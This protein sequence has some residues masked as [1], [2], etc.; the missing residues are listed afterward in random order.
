[1]YNNIIVTGDSMD[2]SFFEVDR[3]NNKID[4]FDKMINGMNESSQTYL[5]MFNGYFTKE[6]ISKIGIFFERYNDIYFNFFPSSLSISFTTEEAD[7]IMNSLE[8]TNSERNRL[9][10]YCSDEYKLKYLEEKMEQAKD[11]YFMGYG[12]SFALRE[13]KSIEFK[14][15]A[16]DMISDWSKNNDKN[17]INLNF[18]EFFNEGEVEFNLDIVDYLMKNSK[19]KIKAYRY[20]DILKLFPDDMKEQLFEKIIVYEKENKSDDDV[21]EAYIRSMLSLMPEEKRIDLF[22]RM[23]YEGV[24]VYSYDLDEL[25]KMFTDE[26]K[27]KILYIISLYEEENVGVIKP[28]LNERVLSNIISTF[29]EEKREKFFFEF[30]NNRN[31]ISI[32]SFLIFVMG[33]NDKLGFDLLDKYLESKKDEIYKNEEQIKKYYYT[34]DYIF[35]N[36][37]V[38]NN[39]NVNEIRDNIAS[40]YIK[41]HNLNKENF[42][43]FISKFGCSSLRF[44]N[45][46]NVRKF[47]NLDSNSFDKALKIFNEE[48]IN[49]N[50]D[51]LN[52]IINSLLQREFLFNNSNVYNIFSYLER[53]VGLA[54]E[55][56]RMEVIIILMGIEKN[57]N[58]AKIL[59]SNNTSMND[60]VDKLFSGDKEALMVLHKITDKYIAKKREDYAKERMK[61]IYDELSLNKKYE[62]NYIKKKFVACSQIFDIK[63]VLRYELKTDNLDMFQK[64]LVNDGDLLDKIIEFKKNPHNNDLEIEHKKEYLRAFDDLLNMAYEQD[65]LKD[66]TDDPNAKYIYSAKKVGMD[67]L[68]NVITELDI[69]RL[70]KMVDDEKTYNELL[71]VLKKFKFLGWGDMFDSMA[72]STDLSF[73]DSAV[74]SLISYFDE[75]IKEMKDSNYSITKLLA[76]SNCYD[77]ESSKYSLLIGKED[78]KYYAANSGK[79]KASA[80]KYKRVEALPELVKGMYNRDKVCVPP[81]DEVITLSNGKKINVVIGNTTN[82]INLTLGERTEACLR[83]YG[84][85]GDLFK[86][87]LMGSDSYNIVL[88]DPDT[89]KFISR[90]TVLCNGNTHF[91]NEL[92]E[93]CHSD[94]SNEDCVEALKKACNMEIVRSRDSRNPIS[95]FVI[96]SDYAMSSYEDKLQPLNVPAKD[97]VRGINHNI[98]NDSTAILLASKEKDGSLSE[99]KLGNENTSYYSPQRDKILTYQNMAAQKRLYQL[100]LIDGLLSGKR[101]EDIEIEKK[102]DIV[103]CISGEDWCIC[104]D[105]YGNVSSYI[106]QNS[107]YREMALIEME[108]YM[109]VKGE[110]KK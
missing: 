51:D 82:M 109:N 16:I 26:D 28:I 61:T 3:I 79:N 85:F 43:K 52:N 97:I 93:S 62:K 94:Y 5:E 77:G 45:C 74:A 27:M 44:L 91:C 57:I 68:L 33:K 1:M 107:K 55:E 78:Y 71:G 13:I 22:E 41:Y 69:T 110:M 40:L 106:V 12:V 8:L 4:D 29:D 53:L 18:D 19:E 15:K 98:R 83:C 72:E 7:K 70:K 34:V 89:M 86:D 90:V 95:N 87:A 96:T 60:L 76:I 66:P 20:V 99:I 54:N 104:T 80:T 100:Q 17:W 38:N 56:S 42:N 58:I 75:V 63:C 88:Y 81:M 37:I 92:R 102:S 73:D 48:N 11:D 84:A 67:N 25:L 32:S 59:K 50:N 39:L 47:I 30:I 105:N 64:E 6:E 24:Y 9:L 101:L 36:E 2:N 21:F 65:K 46:E 49:V 14:H 10:P 31:N 35:S 103:E 23:L 108:K